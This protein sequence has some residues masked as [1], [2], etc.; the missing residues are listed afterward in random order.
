MTA[1]LIG[2]G[3]GYFGVKT[4]RRGRHNRAVRREAEKLKRAGCPVVKAD[5]AG[6]QK[7]PVL[8]R[9]R[10][11][12]YAECPSKTVIVEVETAK[13]AGSTHSRRQRES[14]SRWAGAARRRE[15]LEVVVP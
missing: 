2:L 3:V 1:L 7:P 12:V 9:M 15:F 4:W 10:P 5:V 11:D 13:S 14:F 6:W 8:G